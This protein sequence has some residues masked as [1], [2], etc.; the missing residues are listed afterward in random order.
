MR[1]ESS[2]TTLSWIPSEAVTG[3]EQGDLRDRASRTTTTPPPDVLDDLDAMARRRPVPVRQPVAR[4]D[5]GRGRPHRRRR[6]RRRQRRWARRPCASAGR[7][8]ARFAGG[9]VRR[10]ARRARGHRRR[11]RAFVQTFGGRTALPAPRRVNHPP[12]VQF[13]APTVWTTLALTLHADGR[14][15]CELVGASPFPRHWVYD[16]EGKLAAKA[17]LADFK[18]W[19]RNSFGKH[20]PWGDEDSPA[21]VTAVETALERELSATIMRGGEKPKI[22]KVK[23]GQVLV[24]QGQLGARAVPA[25]RRRA[26]GRGRRRAARPSS[27]PARSSASGRCSRAAA[28]RRRCAPSR[29]VR[30]AVADARPDRPEHLARAERRAPARRE[31]MSRREDHASAGA[32][33]DAGR[34]A[35]SSTRVGGHTSCLASRS[36]T[37]CPT[38]VLDAGTGLQTLAR[39]CSASAPFARHDPAH[40]PALGSRAGLAVL[41]A[42]RSRRRRG[43]RSAQPA[44][45]DPVATLVAGDVAAALPDRAR[46][47][48]AARGRTSRS[49]PGKHEFEGFDVLA[50]DVEHKGGR[51]F[52]YR[53]TRDGASLAYVPDAL[54]DNDDAILELAADVDLFVRGA[55]FVTAEA[56]RADAVRPRHRRARGRDREPRPGRTA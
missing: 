54:D 26:R 19:W 28:A 37:S 32:R 38:L 9:R 52:G 43:R 29:T 30:V 17:G 12:F 14:S 51:A 23:E 11:R 48:C 20:T 2:V 47:A 40:A 27:G 25:A 46:R 33:L 41:P 15:E 56:E 3:A 7:T 36:A 13:E 49:K 5:R 6:L 22:R 34:R 50:R 44:Q 53:V 45:G 4:V 31:P 39:A 1:I 42:G 24:E 55:P 8:C 16:D 10:A 21:L 35:P 18:E